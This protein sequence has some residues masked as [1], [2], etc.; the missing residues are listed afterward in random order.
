MGGSARWPSAT[1]IEVLP[2]NDLL[3]PGLQGLWAERPAGRGPPRGAARGLRRHRQ[4][5]LHRRRH[6]RRRRHAAGA[7]RPVLARPGRPADRLAAERV[8]RLMAPTST[9]SPTTCRWTPMPSWATTR[10]SGLRLGLQADARFGE[11]DL[12]FIG[13]AAEAVDA[14]APWPR[15]G[16]ALGRAPLCCP[17]TA[18]RCGAWPGAPAARR[19]TSRPPSPPAP[20]PSSPA[21][22]PSRRRT[23]RARPASPSWPAATTPPSATARRRWPRTWPRFGLEHRFIDI[24][25]PA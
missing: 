11:Q 18:G 16:R 14:A 9:S 1:I 15:A 6:R 21:R 24:D 3:R 13:P 7:P 4:P 5:G 10:S 17:A 23:W 2:G 8:A 25:N 12:G 19:A 22:S 20:M